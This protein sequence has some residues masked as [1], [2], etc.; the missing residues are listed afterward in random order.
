[1]KRKRKGTGKEIEKENKWKGNGKDI[2]GTLHGNG[3]NRKEI[4]CFL[5]VLLS[6]P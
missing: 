1:M 6:A 3:G 2:K 5:F 4:G